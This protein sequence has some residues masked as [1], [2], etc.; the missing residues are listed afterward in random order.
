MIENIFISII[1][2]IIWFLLG[3]LTLYISRFIFI[4]SPTRRLWKIYSPKNLIICASTSTKTD[5]G[6]YFRPA[7]GI[8]QLRALAYCVESL[9]KVYDI[10]IQNI[11]L[12][13]NQVQKQIE[14]DII[15]LGGPKNN[16]I[17]RMFL[18][19]I[20]YLKVIDQNKGKIIWMLNYP[21]IIFEGQIKNKEVIKDYGLIVRMYN[22]FD[23]QRKTTICL[24]SGSHTYGT[25]A[26]AKYFAYY[27][28]KKMKF[29]KRKFKNI[30]MIVEC[31]IIDG[32]PIDI[33][34]VKKY[35]F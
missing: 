20:K 32:Y 30:I 12:S 13:I 27:Y 14:N 34:M 11:L 3:T 26:A 8:G 21:E 23:S 17:T 2:S 5:T 1:A 9:A 24:F 33:K 10:K 29:Y 35:E 6:E 19:K 18:D 22:P 31:D 28:I 7:T 25:I 4:V 16:E 15:L